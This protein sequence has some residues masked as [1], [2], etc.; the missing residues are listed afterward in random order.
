MPHSFSKHFPSPWEYSMFATYQRL[1]LSVWA[2]ERQV[3]REARK[4]LSEEARKGPLHRTRRHHFYR[5]M[6]AHHT[7]AQQLC[8]KLNL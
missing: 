8:I 1:G 6:L 7:R 5:Q 4:L 3:L 2:S